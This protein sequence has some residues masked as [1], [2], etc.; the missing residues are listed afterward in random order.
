MEKPKKKDIDLKNKKNRIEDRE[1][2]IRSDFEGGNGINFKSYGDDI[3]SFS[4][5]R[6]PGEFY[7]LP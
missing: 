5:L 3:Y 7:S 1:I 4:P 2:I 6:D